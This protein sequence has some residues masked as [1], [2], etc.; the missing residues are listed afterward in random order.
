MLKIVSKKKAV[1]AAQ[2][3]FAKLVRTAWTSRE[4]RNVTWRPNSLEMDIAHNG[5]LWF[6]PQVADSLNA[7]GNLRHW[8]AFGPYTPDGNLQIAVE[9]NLPIGRLDNGV[10]GFVARDREDGDRYLFHDGGIG[11]GVKGVTRDRF[12]A[13][14]RLELTTV[15]VP[16]GEARGGILLAALDDGSG[17]D[18][19]VEFLRKTIAFKARVK[20]ENA[21]GEGR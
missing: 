19:L 3:K 4:R 21:G 11:G 16:E 20:E 9:I 7:N 13:W 18:A 14:S 15:L 8:N 2:G 10:S 17:I 5:Q 1:N 12:L 6:S